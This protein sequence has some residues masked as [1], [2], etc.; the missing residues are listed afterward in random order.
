[1]ESRSWNDTRGVGICVDNWQASAL[2]SNTPVSGDQLADK[3]HEVYS[4]VTEKHP[5][6][7][8]PFRWVAAHK[9]FASNEETY[10]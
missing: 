8:M 6:A 2:K 10:R 3:V 5:Q 7:R 4:R 9:D 1:M